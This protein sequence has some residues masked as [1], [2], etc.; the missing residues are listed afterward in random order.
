MR[1]TRGTSCHCRCA[2]LAREFTSHS[3]RIDPGAARTPAP[4]G[5][6]RESCPPFPTSSAPPGSSRTGVARRQ[7]TE[8]VGLKSLEERKTYLE[9]LMEVEKGIRSEWHSE[10][11]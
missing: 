4:G 8:P 10:I 6:A 5:L 7:R 11:H 9:P 3:E 2:G 1:S